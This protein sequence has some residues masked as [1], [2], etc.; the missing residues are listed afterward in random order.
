MREVTLKETMEKKSGR[1]DTRSSDTE[2]GAIGKARDLQ[3]E[4]ASKE[5]GKS[6]REEAYRGAEI[7]GS[8]RGESRRMV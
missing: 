4:C 6:K 1:P 5:D 7:E 2:L 8:L 3:R